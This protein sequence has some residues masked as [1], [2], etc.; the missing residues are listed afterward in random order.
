MPPD[1]SIVVRVA[2]PLDTDHLVR[3]RT[4]WWEEDRGEQVPDEESFHS[5]FAAWIGERASSHTPFLV[6]RDVEPIGM[7]WLV[8]VDG[9]PWPDNFRRETGHV[10]SVF[11]VAAERSSGV[12]TALMHHLVAHA[13]SIGLT[14][15]MVHPSSRAFPFY[16]R[17]GF[18]DSGKIL[19][20]GD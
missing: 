7:A 14:Y 1:D 5:A 9:I 19:E 4:A 16:R 11:V 10:K 3:L 6:L 18:T 8:Q 12:G 15:L 20:L 2:S 17:L 13:R